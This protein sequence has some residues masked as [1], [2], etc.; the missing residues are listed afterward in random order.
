[1]MQKTNLHLHSKFSDG[2]LWPEEVVA[3]GQR[4]GLHCMALTDHD[5]MEGVERFLAACTATGITGVAGVELDCV[6]GEINYDSELLGYF[7]RGQYDGTRL[8]CEQR[9]QTRE[10]VVQAFVENAARIYGVELPFAE[11][12]RRKLGGDEPENAPYLLSFN[13]VDVWEHLLAVG[14]LPAGTRYREFKTSPMFQIE[15]P[16]KK[17]HAARIIKAV[18][19]DGGYPVLPHPGHIY[20]DDLQTILDNAADLDRKLAFFKD[21]GLW[22]VEQYYYGA[23]P[24]TTE[25]INE[26]VRTIAVR[27]GLALTCGSDCHGPGSRKDTMEQWWLKI[28]LGW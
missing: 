7:P 9:R 22:G 10:V 12:R 13:K 27:H 8:L 28:Q 15:Q 19:Q 18:L 5:S 11:L 14:L 26:L 6:A 2:T 3:R 24:E 17:P 4:V 23:D 25:G 1:M 20:G 16:N 21:A